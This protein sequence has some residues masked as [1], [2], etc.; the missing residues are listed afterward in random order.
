MSEKSPAIT[1]PLVNHLNFY[2][3]NKYGNY[4]LIGIAAGIPDLDTYT[5]QCL[6]QISTITLSLPEN[7][8][9]SYWDN[10]SKKSEI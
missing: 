7:P 4:I 1:T 8:N 6:H 2:D 5:R 10:T 3:M 9:T